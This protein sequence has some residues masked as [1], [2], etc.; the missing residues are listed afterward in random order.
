M[1]SPRSTMYRRVANSGTWW[2]L[3]SASRIEC[4]IV[5]FGEPNGIELIVEVVAGRDRPAAHAGAVRH[6]PVP[7]ER[8]DVVGLLI[9]Q[10]LLEGL[11]ESSALLGIHGATLPD[12]EVVKHGIGV[13]AVVGIAPTR[14]LE[15][16]EI[17]VGIDHVAALE[18]GAELEVPSPEILEVLG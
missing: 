12:V 8:V 17:Q 18:V 15:L 9:E 1:F 6:D 5:L 16:V 4:G 2:I 7:L 13:P 14:G 10:A 11:D 3:D